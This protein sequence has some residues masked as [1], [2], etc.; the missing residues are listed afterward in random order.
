[1]LN[2]KKRI[3]G[4]PIF[5]KYDRPLY[6]LDSEQDSNKY[7]VVVDE[8]NNFD[9]H[10][11]ELNDCLNEKY[12]KINIY[13]K[14]PL[15]YSSYTFEDQYSIKSVLNW[16]N[17]SVWN[18]KKNKNLKIKK[19]KTKYNGQLNNEIPLIIKLFKN[20]N[21]NNEINTIHCNICTESNVIN[22]KNKIKKDKNEIKYLGIK[23]K[24][25]KKKISPKPSLLCIPI[26]TSK[27]S[28]LKKKE[29]KNVDA[30]ISIDEFNFQSNISNDFL[31]VKSNNL[32]E[33]NI[34][35]ERKISLKR[36]RSSEL[37][38]ENP[39]KRIIRIEISNEDNENINIYQN[40]LSKESNEIY[41]NDN[42][43][44]NVDQNNL[45]N[46]KKEI[47]FIN[48]NKQNLQSLVIPPIKSYKSYNNINSAKI[49]S[50]T[51]LVDNESFDYPK[52]QEPT[53]YLPS[54]C[55]TAST[56][57]FQSSFDA[58]VDTKFEIDSCGYADYLKER[59]N[60]QQNA[61]EVSEIE[62]KRFS[63]PVDSENIRNKRN[64][65]RSY[66]FSMTTNELNLIY[67]EANHYVLS[68]LNRVVDDQRH[69]ANRIKENKSENHENEKQFVKGHM[70]TQ[71]RHRRSHAV[72]LS[73]DQINIISNDEDKENKRN[74]YFNKENT[75]SSLNVYSN[76]SKDTQLKRRSTNMIKYKNSNS[77]L[78]SSCSSNRNSYC[79]NSG[80]IRP[81]S[82]NRLSRDID[83]L[84]AMKMKRSRSVPKLDQVE[85][86]NS[87]SCRS[88]VK[89]RYSMDVSSYKDSIGISVKSTPTN[90]IVYYSFNNK[91]DN[92]NNGNEGC[93]KVNRKSY[94]D[95]LNNQTNIDN[96]WSNI[97][98]NSSSGSS[99][100]Y[101]SEEDGIHVI[102]D[103]SIIINSKEDLINYE[104]VN[105]SISDNINNK[106][107]LPPT[108]AINM[109]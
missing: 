36:V 76:S 67:S 42:E 66:A 10:L 16:I 58:K 73:S 104:L 20:K 82:N 45:R 26:K 29:N 83:L 72:C 57:V 41:N 107:V 1:M 80:S 84:R 98:D 109:I 77:S 52:Y 75:N 93:K 18:K 70:R 79:S 33:Q 89:S 108:P 85:V 44:T 51:T 78:S 91:N 55:S 103:S 90:N 6:H 74:K 27:F 24:Q 97:Y 23:K 53:S 87:S 38:P 39:K 62:R 14:S 86:S 31:P 94:G 95:I 17:K 92:K 32:F 25:N 7:V 61:N 63:L 9:G 81:V 65:R 48:K 15:S 2:V 59:I 54:P 71:S 68:G 88:P 47:K 8:I 56:L 21:K 50:A 11:I 30:D 100:Y 37:T 3:D 101:C 106:H 22:I 35:V 28:W 19:S 69:N 49:L 4:I 13:T 105:K 64:R 34:N 102:N 12:E 46:K 43:K 60:E 96:R 40:N 5:D 99:T